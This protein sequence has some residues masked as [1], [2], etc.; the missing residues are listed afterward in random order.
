MSLESE[1]L[2][3]DFPIR[4]SI[5]MHSFL[6]Y[7]NLSFPI[8]GTSLCLTFKRESYMN[9][10][11]KICE[12]KKLQCRSN[13]YVI[14]MISLLKIKLSANGC[15]FSGLLCKDHISLFR[16]SEQ[17]YLTD[18]AKRKYGVTIIWNILKSHWQF[19][20]WTL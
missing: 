19:S 13:T 9:V 14:F 3:S 2:F 12:K 4:F 15:A 1:V 6:V 17:L 11:A 16:Y 20:Y 8:P 7:F 18:I 5:L 10:I